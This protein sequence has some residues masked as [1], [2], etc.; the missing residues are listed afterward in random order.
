MK[1]ETLKGQAPTLKGIK[2]D[3]EYRDTNLKSIRITDLAGK[4]YVIAIPN[5]YSDTLSILEPAPPEMEDV[6]IVKHSIA[7]AQYSKSFADRYEA[8]DFLRRLQRIDGIESEMEETKREKVEQAESVAA[9]DQ[10]F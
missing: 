6:F 7:E 1:L 5:T 8:Q 4:F 3:L 2:F 9:D 10:P